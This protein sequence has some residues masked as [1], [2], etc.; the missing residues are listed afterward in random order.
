ME[1]HVFEVQLYTDPILGVKLWLHPFQ[2]P[3]F[4]INS[5][6]RCAFFFFAV[7]SVL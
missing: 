2:S 4:N 3:D 5:L 6:L 1:V 7:L